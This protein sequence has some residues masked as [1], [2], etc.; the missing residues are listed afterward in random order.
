MGQRPFSL[1][2]P[3]KSIGLG[4]YGGAARFL[5]SGNR[6]FLTLFYN[7]LGSLFL[8]LASL[9]DL[10]GGVGC[11]GAYSRSHWSIRGQYALSYNV[12]IIG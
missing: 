9:S 5:T 11:R 4:Y 6:T 3:A 8:I 1:F 12:D 10:R 7:F 2:L